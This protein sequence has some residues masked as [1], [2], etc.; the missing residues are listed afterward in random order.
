MS[1]L[2]QSDGVGLALVREATLNTQ[3]T[4]GWTQAQPNPGGITNFTRQN[5]AVDRH[6]LSGNKTPERGEVVGYDVSPK[7]AQD[8]N[9]D[10]LDLMSELVFC[11]S[12]KHGGNKGQ[13]IYRATA[14]TTTGYTVAALGDL[15]AGL[16]IF[17][18]GFST[19]ANNGLKVVGSSSTGTE[20]KT[21]GL[22]AEASPPSN[23]TVRIAGV[24]G[25]ASDI[26]MDGSGNLTSTILDLTTLGLVVGQMIYVGDPT[27]GAIYAF[28]NTVYTGMAIVSIIAAGKVTLKY[29]TWT[30]GSLDAGTGK[31]I[32]LLFESFI[33][34]VPI[35]H[36]DYL[37]SAS[38]SMELSEPGAGAAG[39]T[40]YTYANG[41]GLDTL[42]LD[43]P[44]EGKVTASI[45]LVGMTMTSPATSRS[46]G[47]STAYAPLA[48][49]IF[50]TAANMP[51]IRLLKQSDGTTLSAEINGCKVMIKNNLKPRKQL[52]T[53]GAAGLIYGEYNPSLSMNA[54]VLSNDMSRAVD[55]NTD[56]YFDFL[57]KNSDGG[58]GMSFAMVKLR[59]GDKTYAAGTS[60][61][62]A[63]E[64]P[65]NR[66]PS[67]GLLYSMSK[68]SYLP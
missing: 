7:L 47:P 63:G 13:S 38:W 36:A 32:R 8:C 64:M 18:E 28:A 30:V 67:T 55:G 21:S 42:E 45:G 46:T 43:I 37:A 12:T 10:L 27:S 2:V 20:I 15:T 68:F 51:A 25:A 59:K 16:L 4:S 52:G 9:R 29:Q 5:V 33:R 41:C 54:Y 22:T 49:S 11:S 3:P 61:M 56:C 40:D 6:I 60:V 24:Q 44:V 66:D 1:L 62:L 17:A 50:S 14:V 48:S 58:F 26:T 53:G 65:A 35:T 23:A 57:L 31:T 34:N 19:A 39:V